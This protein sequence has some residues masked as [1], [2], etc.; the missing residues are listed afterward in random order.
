MKIGVV[1]INDNDNY[2]N[3]LQAYAVLTVLKSYNISCESICNY[4]HLN[5]KKNYLQRFIKYYSK[6][7]LYSQEENLKNLIDL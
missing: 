3:R 5:E 6:R 2:G 1:T 7:K 4:A